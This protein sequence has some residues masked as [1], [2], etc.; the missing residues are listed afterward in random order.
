MRMKPRAEELLVTSDLARI[1]AYAEYKKRKASDFSDA[2]K[3]YFGFAQ[4][5]R[6]S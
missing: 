1:G 5:T 2:L 4:I 3:A 6:T